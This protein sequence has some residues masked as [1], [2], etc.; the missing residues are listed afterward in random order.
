MSL[1]PQLL[2]SSAPAALGLSAEAETEAQ[3]LLMNNQVLIWVDANIN[4]VVLLEQLITPVVLTHT[5][6]PDLSWVRSLVR[7]KHLLISRSTNTFRSSAA[8]T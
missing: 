3:M 8:V 1:A 7:L 5:H 4:T 6:T 2:S